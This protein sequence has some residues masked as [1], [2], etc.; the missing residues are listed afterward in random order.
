M[1]DQLKGGRS[2]KSV[3]A[4]VRATISKTKPFDRTGQGLEMEIPGELVQNLFSAKERVA[5]S[6]P[7]NGAHFIARV[8]EIKAAGPG[9]DKQGIDAI[10]Q[11]IGAGIGND[12]TDGL[13]SALQ[14]RLGVTINREAVNAYF[15]IGDRAP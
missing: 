3:A 5:R 8:R 6:A 15:N 13:A 12:L 9:A 14:V 1:I 7:G 10:R 11:Q 2:F 4:K